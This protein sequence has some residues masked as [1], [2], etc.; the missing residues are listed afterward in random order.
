MI[1]MDQASVPNEICN[2]QQYKVSDPGSTIRKSITLAAAL[3]KYFVI[4]KQEVLQDFKSK[5]LFCK[6]PIGYIG[7]FYWRH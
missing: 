7:L 2:I 6:I 5:A 1:L 4:L 3:Q